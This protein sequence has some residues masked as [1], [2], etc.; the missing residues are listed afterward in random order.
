[1]RLSA[2]GAGLLLSFVI[3]SAEAPKASA[4][5]V[6]AL[7]LKQDTA[8]ADR[9]EVLAMV[10]DQSEARIQTELPASPPQPVKHVVAEGDTL[11]SIA[12]QYQTTW[13]RLYAKNTHLAHPDVISHGLELTIPAADEQ[14]A[15]RALPTPAPEPV[16]E[17][18]PAA[19]KPPV[20]QK[21]AQTQQR[22]IRTQSAA[23]RGSSTGNTYGYGYCTWYAKNRRM[24]LPNNL[25]NADT[26]VSR[27]AAQ[28]L[29]TGSEPRAGAIGQRGMHVVYVEAVN[30]DGTV[31]ISEMNREGWN[32]ISSRTVSSS[33]FRYIY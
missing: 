3:F 25:G 18:A 8:T 2:L 24:D 11:S 27:A 5:T 21:P 20:K 16:V 7:P 31:T 28:G 30:G 6:A 10:E 4:E 23:P 29:A 32:V 1:M 9:L 15:E 12:I 26:W 17:Q 33:Y 22:T 13:S 19:V 14:L